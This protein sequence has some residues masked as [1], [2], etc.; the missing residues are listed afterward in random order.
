MKNNIY[1]QYGCGLS[2]PEKWMNFDAS[3]TLIMQ[4]IPLIGIFFKKKVNFPDNIRYGDILKGLTGVEHNSCQGIYCSHVL[5]HLAYNDFQLALKNTY[6]NLKPGGIFRC[7]LPDLEI[8]IK[9]YLDDLNSRPEMA[10]VDFLNSTMLGIKS[11]PRGIINFL[12][13]HFGNSPH[14]WMH[15]QYELKNAL[16]KAGFVDVRKCEFNDSRDEMFKLVEEESRFINSIAFECS[17]PF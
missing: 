17:K 13:A 8:S 15:D 6:L 16:E 10:S 1:M 14:L 12:I 2:A 5:E 11:R 9:K 4:K 7:V 3:P